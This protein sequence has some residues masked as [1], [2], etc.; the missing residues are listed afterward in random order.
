[1]ATP[2]CFN[3]SLLWYQFWRLGRG[4]AFGLPL[5]RKDV[6]M[7]NSCEWSTWDRIAC[8]RPCRPH[9]PSKVSW[10]KCVQSRRGLSHGWPFL[11]SYGVTCWWEHIQ[12]GLS[13][14]LQKSCCRFSQMRDSLAFWHKI[15]RLVFHFFSFVR[16]L[17]P[18]SESE[19]PHLW[20]LQSLLLLWVLTVYI[21]PS[22]AQG[23]VSDR[24]QTASVYKEHCQN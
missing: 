23:S 1:M 22:A 21:L 2:V 15:C 18:G 12:A 14:Y 10:Q 9:V 5:W 24:L 17:W 6:A 3:G 8:Q 16:L 13:M 20:L 7:Q 11:R 19:R 4:M